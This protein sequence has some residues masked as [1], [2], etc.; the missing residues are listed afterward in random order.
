M[1]MKSNT[2]HRFSIRKLTIGAVSV[3]FG[4]LVF[5]SLDANQ[6]QAAANDQAPQA[7]VQTAGVTS[8]KPEAGS[9]YNEEIQKN[10]PAILVDPAVKERDANAA[11]TADGVKQSVSISAVNKNT[12]Q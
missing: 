12:N 9:N 8:A 4:I 5:T 3:M 10:A 11:S 2:V 7:A 6:A 1:R